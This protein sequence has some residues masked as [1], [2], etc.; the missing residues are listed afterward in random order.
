MK[1]AYTM[2]TDG[3]CGN[4]GQCMLVDQVLGEVIKGQKD[5]D[6]LPSE[7]LFFLIRE[8]SSTEQEDLDS[9]SND[10]FQ[11]LRDRIY[12]KNIYHDYVYNAFANLVYGEKNAYIIEFRDIAQMANYVRLNNIQIIENLR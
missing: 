4:W 9:L 11:D 3:N 12:N 8:Y 1:F 10:E 7:L 5:I 2:L 6:E